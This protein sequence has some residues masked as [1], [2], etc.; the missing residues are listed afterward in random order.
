MK[1]RRYLQN[2]ATSLWIRQ[3]NK[4]IEK[5]EPIG[6]YMNENDRIWTITAHFA[7]VTRVRNGGG[8]AL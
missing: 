5:Y 7:V 6:I 1:H 4:V 8:T 3:A 2:F